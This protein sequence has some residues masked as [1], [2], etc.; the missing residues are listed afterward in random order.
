MSDNVYTA[1]FVNQAVL[2]ALTTMRDVKAQG[3]IAIYVDT[4]GDLQMMTGGLLSP[5][6]MAIASMMM[7]EEAKNWVF[8][9]EY[10]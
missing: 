1:G 7:E 3:I 2:E 6:H 4:E 5:S 9:V 8:G 10:D